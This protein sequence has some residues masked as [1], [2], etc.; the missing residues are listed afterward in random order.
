MQTAR[1]RLGAHE[2]DDSHQSS[3]SGDRSTDKRALSFSDSLEASHLTEKSCLIKPDEDPFN[4]SDDESLNSD[5]LCQHIDDDP[6]NCRILWQ[7]A[8]GDESCDA[9]IDK[10]MSDDE[11]MTGHHSDSIFAC[12]PELCQPILSHQSEIPETPAS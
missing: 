1:T 2:T 6:L 5:E 3:R 12:D 10:S 11:E 7:L 4:G 8:H 9:H